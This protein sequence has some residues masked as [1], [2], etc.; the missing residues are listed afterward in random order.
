VTITKP[1]TALAKLTKDSMASDN[2]PTE[3]VIHQ[4]KVLRVMVKMATTT[5]A[6]MR[7]RGD[8][9]GSFEIMASG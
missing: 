8:Q 9:A 6:H 7:V 4:A 1:K 2:K 5:D 3:S